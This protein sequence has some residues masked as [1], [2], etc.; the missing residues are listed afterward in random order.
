MPYDFS[1]A[2]IP[3]NESLNTI[4]SWHISQD[5][6]EQREPVVAAEPVPKMEEIVDYSPKITIS[7]QRDDYTVKYQI[8]Q[9]TPLKKVFDNFCQK[10]NMQRGQLRFFRD[11]DK[12]FDNDC[13]KDVGLEDG[14]VITVMEEQVGGLLFL[15]E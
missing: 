5:N 2:K 3:K 12:L 13:P 15:R 9:T 10:V 1:A 11:A 8:K 6:F 14:A 4:D 7:V